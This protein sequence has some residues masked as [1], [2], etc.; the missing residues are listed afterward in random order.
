MSTNPKQAGPW[1]KPRAE[2]D[3]RI[4][5]WSDEE[6]SETVPPQA[7][8]KRGRTLR[9]WAV[10]A[11]AFL[12]IFYVIMFLVGGLVLSNTSNTTTTSSGGRFSFL[13]GGEIAVIP[14]H[15]E[16]SS[17]TSKDSVGYA[18]VIAAL[19][20]AD[21]DPAIRVIFLDISSGGGGVVPSK[22]IVSKIRDVKK[23]VVSWIGEMGASGAYYIASS[24]DYILADGDSITGS[25][26]VISMLPSL[27]ELMQKVGVKMNTIK[28]GELKDVG[29]PFNEFTDEERA[30]FQTIVDEAFDS[31]KNDVQSF[32]GEKLNAVK[33]PEVLDGR[34][35]SGR[36]ALSVGLIDELGTREQ[37]IAKAAALGE[38]EGEPVRVYYLQHTPT[39]MDLLFSA[40]ASFGSGIKSEINPLA[41]NETAKIEAK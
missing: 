39:L 35:L 15:G 40:G 41:G 16:I 12:L 4:T 2:N 17:A 31:F 1:S 30:I 10:L 8:R 18:D 9:D 13:S 27:D 36:Q 21:S 24:S 6:Y 29:S 34:I 20:D 33:F 38:I 37:A 7:P 5:P 22:Q 14:I 25:I 32:R 3:P 11:L 23:P 19:D 26:G 28:T